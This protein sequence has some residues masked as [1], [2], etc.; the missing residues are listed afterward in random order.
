MDVEYIFYIF[1][2]FPDNKKQ[3]LEERFEIIKNLNKG[4][5]VKP[6]NL[7][8]GLLSILKKLKEKEKEVRLLMLGLD[9]A[10][11]TTIIYSNYNGDEEWADSEVGSKELSKFI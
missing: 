7:S 4:T 6:E 1:L 3:K 10:G 9:N 11:K 2:P 5:I 8:M